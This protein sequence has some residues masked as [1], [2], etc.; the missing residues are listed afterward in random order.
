M[1]KIIL[2]L[3]CLLPF[4][5]QAQ[6]GYTITGK[7]GALNPP[8]KAYL[9]YIV[10]GKRVIDS[11][12]IN[13]GAFQFKGS[14]PA[15]ASAGITIKHDAAPFNKNIDVLAF[16]LEN[17]NIKVSSPDSV[18]RAV[19]K[20]SIINDENKELNMTLKPIKTKI[21]ALKVVWTGVKPQP[22]NPAYVKAAD[23]LRKMIAEEKALYMSF[24][25]SH[26]N[27][28]IALLTFNNIAL[29]YN[30]DPNVAEKAFNKF[31]AALKASE[32]GKQEAEKIALAK[33]SQNGAIAT[34]FT[35]NDVNG[36]PV[37]LSDFRGKYVLVDFWASWCG[38]CRAENPNVVKAYNQLKGKNF[39]IIGISLDDKKEPWVNAIAHDGLP[40]VQ[41]SDLKG[42]K[43]EVALQYGIDAIPQNILVDPTGVVIA[44]NLR[45]DEL[46]TKLST[47]VK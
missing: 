7:V 10:H 26:P 43:N 30:F 17:A 11:V 36:K 24:I 23:S 1:K 18:K 32:L 28:Y 15:P 39:E 4:V 31:S 41:V 5:V 21:N 38:P 46:L 8:A 16:Y 37:K 19:I 3:M 22:E 47:L 44:K 25:G 42:F 12:E 34:D 45:G 6:N 13:H 29:G 9:V 33:K 2:I 14:V 27:S 20:G 35:Q 40:W